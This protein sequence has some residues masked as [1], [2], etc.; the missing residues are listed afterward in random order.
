M[1]TENLSTLKIHKLSQAQ[2]DRELAAGR[3]DETALYL[4]PD[5]AI[6][7]SPYVNQNAFS[8]VTVGSTTITADSATDTLTLAAGNN[9]TIT[10]DASGDKITI[11]AKDTTYSAATATSSGL[12][13]SFDY[14]KLQQFKH[15]MTGVFT[16][17]SA[18]SLNIPFSTFDITVRP[19]V[20]LAIPESFDGIVR[21]DFDS[22]SS[23]VVLKIHVLDTDG[24][25]KPIV[26]GAVIRLG[27]LVMN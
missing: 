9:I 22:S 16:T 2:Y 26:S 20:V 14:S 27:L 1:N 7:F 8:K 3:I 5:E 24:T 25:L 19:A 15:A 6:D 12:M 18:G 10:P 21:Y 13:S 4:T 17:Q 11:S 23:Q